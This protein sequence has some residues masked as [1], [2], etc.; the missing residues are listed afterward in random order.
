MAGDAGPGRSGNP[1]PPEGRGSP[2]V[3]PSGWRI[4]HCRHSWLLL[5]LLRLPRRRHHRRMGEKQKGLGR[6]SGGETDV[7]AAAAL[8]PGLGLPAGVG[9]GA[10]PRGGEQEPGAALARGTAVHRHPHPADPLRDDRLGCPPR[11]RAHQSDAAQPPPVVT[12]PNPSMLGDVVPPLLTGF[13]QV[14]NA[15]SSPQVW[16]PL[17][18]HANPPPRVCLL[19]L[20]HPRVFSL[21]LPFPISHCSFHFAFRW[22]HV[23]VPHSSG[24]PQASWSLTPKHGLLPILVYSAWPSL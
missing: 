18:Q 5:P 4:I 19:R 15:F 3:L 14:A 23:T 16:E 8:R 17:L 12:P 24:C 6:S 9:Q 7:A 10:G 21:Q 20:H 22:G 2:G 1:G 13:C 11:S